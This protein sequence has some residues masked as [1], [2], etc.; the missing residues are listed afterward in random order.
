MSR[1]HVRRAHAARHGFL[2]ALRV[3]LPRLGRG[4]RQRRGAHRR[5][6]PSRR[7][8]P[9]R[10][11]SVG[12]M[13]LVVGALGIAGARLS[14]GT[15]GEALALSAGPASSAFPEDEAAA[16]SPGFI[17][18]RPVVAVVEPTPLRPS[19]PSTPSLEP[20]GLDS[21]RRVLEEIDTVAPKGLSPKSVVFVPGGRFFAQNMMYN[22]TISVFDRSLRRIANIADE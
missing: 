12:L 10:S 21:S 16:F 6:A 11:G 5:A 13:V 20:D 14:F 9:G 15:V 7:L 4:K 17:G 22:H 18:S 1:Q 8:G 19:S 2:S 3:S